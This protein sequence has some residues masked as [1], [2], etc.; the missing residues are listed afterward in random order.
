MLIVQEQAWEE[1]LP[2]DTVWGLGVRGEDEK[3]NKACWEDGIERYRTDGPIVRE[4]LRLDFGL[5]TSI[6]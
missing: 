6:K 3:D 1:N 2:S 4:K 5:P